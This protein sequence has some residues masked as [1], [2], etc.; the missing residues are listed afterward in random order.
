MTEKRILEIK[1]LAEEVR[2]DNSLCSGLL[3]TTSACI[4]LG[5]DLSL[6]YDFAP[7]KNSLGGNLEAYACMNSLGEK[8][9]VVSKSLLE[10]ST[11]SLLRAT[12]GL[13]F[14]ALYGGKGNFMITSDGKGYY[15]HEGTFYEET[16][17]FA[18]HFLLPEVLIREISAKQTVIIPGELAKM[19][20][21]SKDMMK[22]RLDELKLAYTN[23]VA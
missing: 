12:Q 9:L 4:H 19:F 6:C 8:S 11:L 20:E 2:R 15:N 5:I 1:K 17:E 18:K 21:V 23:Y 14:F 3:E 16:M 22:E 10:N 7:W 13:A